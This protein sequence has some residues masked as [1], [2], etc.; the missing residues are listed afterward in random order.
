MLV[1]NSSAMTI[2]VC[3]PSLSRGVLTVSP[4]IQHN[5]IVEIF[6]FIY[7]LE[8]K[9]QLQVRVDFWIEQHHLVINIIIT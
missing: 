6:C 3:I 7:R 5:S 4:F 9:N 8:H 2:Y 1:A